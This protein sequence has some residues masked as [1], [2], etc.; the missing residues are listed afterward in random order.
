MYSGYMDFFDAVEKRRTIRAYQKKD[1]DGELLRKVIG[2]VNLAPSAN[3][4]QSYEIFVVVD[5]SKKRILLEGS[6]ADES[7]ADASALML[8]CANPNRCKV[9][10]PELANLLSI[11]DTTIAA[12]YAQLAAAALGLATSWIS[13]VSKNS[14][15]K[16]GIP[17]DLVPVTI[18]PLG[19]AAESPPK[20]QRRGINNIMHVL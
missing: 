6:S 17:N 8:F 14:L 3:N 9:P 4:L 16:L 15:E 11:E 10:V 12:A 18:I 7:I 20:K 19:Y 5:D 1:L 13:V 2:A